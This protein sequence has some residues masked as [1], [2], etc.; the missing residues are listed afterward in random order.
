[1]KF[2]VASTDCD[3]SENLPAELDVKGDT[4]DR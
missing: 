1:M 2:S 4:L 3:M